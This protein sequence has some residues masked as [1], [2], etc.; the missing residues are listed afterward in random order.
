MQENLKNHKIKLSKYYIAYID[1]LGIKKA[2]SSSE[3]ENYLNKIKELYD[4][5]LELIK[6]NCNN[7]YF[8]N[9][10]IKIFSDNI[11]IAIKKT[12]QL[13]FGT[14]N[15]VSSCYLMIFT[16]FFQ[17][18]AL[19]Y[20][21]LVRGAIVVDDLYI[22]E[23]LIY[24]KALSTAYMLESEI[25]NYPRIIINPENIHLFTKSDMQQK[26]LY[27][28]SS[29]LYYLNPFEIYFDY[30]NEEDKEAN[31]DSI[32]QILTA[33]LDKT[34]SIKI[35]QKICWFINMFNDFCN[36]YKYDNS[37]I[38]ID[39]YPYP[40]YKPEVYVTARARDFVNEEFDD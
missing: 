16:S 11:V 19:K 34:N 24:G 2:I 30:L 18:L 4:A 12:E 9:A 37:V 20:S 3:S 10:K 6:A 5:T 39:N 7:Q 38:N 36:K 25:A 33:K 27:K 15:D 13:E 23:N 32:K 40:K 14:P 21:F 26:A 28:D 17:T 8:L 35:N 29:N 31:I 22:D 1:I